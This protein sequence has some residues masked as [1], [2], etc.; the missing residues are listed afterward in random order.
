MQG[1]D[2]G[3]DEASDTVYRDVIMLALAGFMTIVIL[4]L[5]H[6]NPKAQAMVAKDA[7]PP[8]NVMIEANWP[9]D[10]DSDVDLWV[11]APGDRPVGYS[12]KGGAVFNLLRD[13]LGHQLDISGLNYESSFSRGVIPGEYTVNLHLYRNRA[14]ATDVPVTVVVSVKTQADMPARQLL[15]TKLDLKREGEERTVFRFQLTEAGTIVP[16]SV[17]SLQRPLRS[18]TKS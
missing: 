11:Q 7:A 12:N 5:A 10:F 1:L 13:D 17:N 18:G 14:R 6:L 16:G 8:G 15:M 2:D 9:P 3:F 4:M